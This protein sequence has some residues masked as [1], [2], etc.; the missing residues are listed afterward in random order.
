VLVALVVALLLGADLLP[1]AAAPDD[2]ALRARQERLEAERAGLHEDLGR[3]EGERSRVSAALATATAEVDRLTG[4]LNRLRDETRAIEEEVAALEGAAAASRDRIARRVGALY[5]GAAPNDF[6]GLLAGASSA[7][8]AE[9]SHY[10][11]ALTRTDRADLETAAAVGR[12]LVVRRAD[13][14][15]ATARQEA[16]AQE[17]RLAWAELD[18]QLAAAGQAV[19]G[20]RGRIAAGEDEARSIAG[21]LEARRQARARADQV[22]AERRRAEGRAREAA[23]RRRQ[24]APSRSA[25]PPAAVPVRPP[26]RVPA[27]PSTRA[28][29]APPG[30]AGMACPQDHPR[31]FTDTWG[32]PRSGGRRHQG[33][34]IFGAMGG[35]VF[36][37]TS[38]TVEWARSGGSAGRWL[39]LRGDDGDRYWYMHLSG[40]V[41]SGGQ[42][43][44]AGELIAYNGDTGNARGTSPHIHFEHHPGGGRPVN[45]YPLLRRVCG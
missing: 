27:A 32:A 34:D 6:L 39:S 35:N 15:E 21:E 36:A 2:A 25:P 30:G 31:S 7:E 23:E 41:A 24:V 20:V 8:V 3:A 13:L 12:R 10:L 44:G 1:A 33:T 19:A 5:R 43:V 42:R 16:V 45:P 14:A 9:R 22:A 40:F 38:G 11:V 4:E 37:I 29:P 26:V 17:S 18:R 28:A